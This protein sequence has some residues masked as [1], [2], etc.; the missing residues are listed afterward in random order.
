MGPGKYENIGNSQSV[1]IRIDPIISPRPVPVS[2]AVGAAASPISRPLRA[3]ASKIQAKGWVCDL[4]PS[5]HAETNA[6]TTVESVAAQ[7]VARRRR[8]ALGHADGGTR[9][10]HTIAGIRPQTAA[11]SY[12]SWPRHMMC[13]C[14]Y[15]SSCSHQPWT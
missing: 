10:Q 5:P 8:S 9:R 7:M 11:G 13:T 14:T 3:V 6:S 12:H 4:L 1:L 2:A 15:R